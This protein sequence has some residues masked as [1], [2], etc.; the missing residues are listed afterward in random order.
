MYN[1]LKRIAVFLLFLIPLSVESQEISKAEVYLLTCGPGTEIYSVYGHSAVRV[2]IKEQNFDTVY[3]WGLFDFDTPNFA[4]K[5]AQGRLD[6]MLGAESYDGF[7][8]TYYSERRWVIS[9]KMNLDQDDTRQIL[10]LISEN[11]KPENRKYR[12]DFYYDNCSS[13]IRDIIE[14]ATGDD[15]VYPIPDAKKKLST[16]RE[17]TGEYQKGYPWLQFGID[18]LIGCGGDKKASFRDRMFLPID[19]YKGLSELMVKNNE[20]VVPLLSNPEVV[21][22]FESPVVK[23]HFFT[24]PPFIFT[25]VLIIIIILT[26]LIRTRRF[27][28]VLDICVFSIF[29]ILAIL[30]VFFNVFSAHQ[31]LKWNLNIIWL[32]PFLLICLFGLLT[33]KN[34]E[35]WYRVTFY[36]ALFFL[37]TITFLPQNINNASVPLIFILIIRSSVR[38]GF[39]WNP[40]SLP[41]LT[42]L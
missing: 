6:Y 1:Y 42:E 13:R 19:L 20:K 35:I 27:N 18:L 23:G 21:I 4:F 32:N 34:P 33:G 22:D 39:I 17:L 15:L 12:Y 10:N 28:N 26:A 38:A 5:F 7:L 16:F 24:S 8:R 36:L 41:H 11:L 9:Q 14:K 30:M 31:Q 40:L 29:S 2:V 37:L 3:N 25:L